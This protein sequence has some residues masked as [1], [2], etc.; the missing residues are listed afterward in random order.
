MLFGAGTVSHT[1]AEVKALGCSRALVLCT[2]EQRA[3]AERL[4]AMLG[5]C[6][7]AI[8]SEATMHTPVTVTER[9]MAG[10]ERTGADCTVAI[11]GGS[12][13]GLGKAIALRTGLPQVVVPTTYAGSEMT[14]VL[15]ETAHGE[16]ITQRSM[17]V[18]P[19]TV[20]YDVELTLSLPAALSATSGIN[21]MAHAVEALYTAN[22]NPVTSMMAE[23]SI[24]LLAH[25]LPAIVR[26]PRD[27]AARA[28]ALQGSWLAGICLATAGMALHH[29]LCH[30]LGGS[31]GLPHAATHTVVLPHVIAYNAAAAPGAMT[32]V[33]RALRT[34]DAATG[35]Y[36]LAGRLGAERSLAALGMPGDGIERAARIAVQ[37]PYP[38]PAE[39][40]YGRVRDLLTA[41]WSGRC[42]LR[43][44]A[45]QLR[46]HEGLPAMRSPS[47]PPACPAGF[48]YPSADGC[49]AMQ[50]SR[51]LPCK[52]RHR[53][54]GDS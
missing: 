1:A 10:L 36:E 40:D 52:Y 23:E 4:G 44:R 15:G 5:T 39:L 6:L 54:A 46:G 19:E 41:A 14:P 33:A 28:D 37:H 13:I 11:G 32:R 30:V 8:F 3:D 42:P 21:A 49:L 22:A 26:N 31:F 20:I 45:D 38:N 12:T 17:K 48:E 29:K 16:K 47:S 53:P 24:R 9:A 43:P 35:V 34:G 27:P 7:A 18:L 51:D 25:A 50:L 2:P